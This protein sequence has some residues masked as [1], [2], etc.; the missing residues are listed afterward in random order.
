MWR[1]KE[2]AEGN[3]AGTNKK[4]TIEKLNAL[5]GVIEGIE[6]LELG[7]NFNSSPAAFDLVLITTHKTKEALDNYQ[8]HPKHQE[9]A[10]FIGSVIS[11]RHVVDFEY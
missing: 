9:A 2:N 10:K 3:D 1:F 11:M 7:E 5:V 6:S 8:Q 4:L